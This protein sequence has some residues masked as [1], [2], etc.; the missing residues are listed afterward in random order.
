MQLPDKCPS[1][2]CIGCMNGACKI[3]RSGNR[4]R[5]DVINRSNL[6]LQPDLHRFSGLS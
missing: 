2:L 4:V 3:Y 1:D 6:I 5:Q